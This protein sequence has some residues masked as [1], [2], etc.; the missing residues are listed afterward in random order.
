NSCPTKNSKRKASPSP[1]RHFSIPADVGT[2]LW[3]RPRCRTLPELPHECSIAL[4]RV[5]KTR[6]KR[7]RSPR[8]PPSAAAG[9]QRSAR[10]F[11]LVREQSNRSRVPFFRSRSALFSCQKFANEFFVE[12]DA[13]DQFFLADLLTRRM[14]I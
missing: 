12:V 13:F 8:P 7:R 2:S 3:S 11:P 5:S 9:N 10:W 14:R 1:S 6:Y 4:H